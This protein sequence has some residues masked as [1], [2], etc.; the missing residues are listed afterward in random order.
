M[1]LTLYLVPRASTEWT[2]AGRWQGEAD[3]P[4]T[5]EGLVQVQTWAAEIAKMSREDSANS[6]PLPSGV[7]QGLMEALTGEDQPAVP[8][9]GKGEE[10]VFK[11]G[12]HL[13]AVYSSAGLTARSTAETLAALLSVP[14][15][16]DPHLAEVA[17]GL[18]QGLTT[19]QLSTRHG[20]AFRAW[21]D[22]P[23]LITPPEGESLSDARNRLSKTLQRFRRKY[24]GRQLAIVLSP[25]SMALMRMLLTGTRWDGFWPLFHEPEAS[26]RFVVEKK[27]K[28]PPAIKA[29]DENAAAATKTHPHPA[30]HPKQSGLH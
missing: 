24:D 5:P 25:L 10:N 8:F 19:D 2:A 6:P 11:P 3:L 4:P 14:A 22:D 7:W 23:A 18:W 30:S 20:K 1:A 15:E 26:H 12:E 28:S 9:G 17:L 13:A 16:T 29:S 21:E 27:R